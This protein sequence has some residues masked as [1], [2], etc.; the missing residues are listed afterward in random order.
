MPI[1]EQGTDPLRENLALAT[2]CAPTG[3]STYTTPQFA[4]SLLRETVPAAFVESG[5]Q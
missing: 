3:T 2:E 5:D 1:F 4:P